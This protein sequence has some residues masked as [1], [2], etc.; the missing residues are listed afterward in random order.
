MTGSGVFAF[1]FSH[2]A[3]EADGF[4]VAVVFG[5]KGLEVVERAG[6]V[7]V[8]QVDQVDLLRERPAV[9]EH[10]EDVDVVRDGVAQVREAH[11]RD[12][13]GGKALE[14]DGCADRGI[15]AGDIR[16]RRNM[17]LGKAFIDQFADPVLQQ[18]EGQFRKVLD[19]RAVRR[20][21]FDLRRFIAVVFLQKGIRHAQIHL[22]VQK[23]LF[24]QARVVAP[25]DRD[26]KVQG[27]VQHE[28]DELRGDRVR[29]P[30]LHLRIP[31]GEARQDMRQA[32]V[33]AQRA[34]AEAQKPA[35]LLL[36]VEQNPFQVRFLA[37]HDVCKRIHVLAGGRQRKPRLSIEQLRAVI[38]LQPRDVVRQR[39]LRDE[40]P[41]RRPRHMQVLRKL[42]EIIQANQLHFR[43]LYK[44]IL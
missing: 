43:H 11:A 5:E 19:H 8:L 1:L 40:Q 15:G 14:A 34:R 25:Y 39:L 35:L 16:P 41:L 42:R 26:R 36:D 28:L 31:L 7:A 18:A 13:R 12:E 27:L 10:R 32:G 44:I 21:S 29:Q 38:A 33:H 2:Y 22:I 4:D 30:E 3:L 24:D 9:V 37:Q 23:L 17:R 20:P 6:E